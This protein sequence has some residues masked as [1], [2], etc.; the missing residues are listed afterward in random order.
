M[1]WRYSTRMFDYDLGWY[2]AAAC[3]APVEIDGELLD[4]DA[5]NRLFY[6]DHDGRRRREQRLAVEVCTGCRVRVDC[7]TYAIAAQEPA[8]IWGGLTTE[9]RARAINARRRKDRT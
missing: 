2:D 3:R 5:V 8:G 9:E 7:L 4:R 6:S 1:R